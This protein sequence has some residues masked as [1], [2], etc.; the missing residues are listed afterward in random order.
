MEETDYFLLHKLKAQNQL[1]MGAGMKEELKKRH[2]YIKTME[3]HF[4]MAWQNVSLTSCKFSVLCQYCDYQLESGHLCP[5]LNAS[6]VQL[7]LHIW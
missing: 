3:L 6:I 5:E 4:M 7:V 2:D 1:L